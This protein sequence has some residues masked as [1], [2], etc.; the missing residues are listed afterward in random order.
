MA[1]GAIKDS[2]TMV[3]RVGFRC[4]VNDSNREVPKNNEAALFVMEMDM[5][6][7]IPVALDRLPARSGGDATVPVSSS[8]IL[9]SLETVSVGRDDETYLLRDHEPI[10]KTKTAQGIVF[11]AI[12]N[13][14]RFKIQK[15]IG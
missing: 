7:N 12:E 9:P 11:T 10:F 14:G 15:K 4:Y 13:L 5:P 2:D 3:S 6:A 1:L 8:A